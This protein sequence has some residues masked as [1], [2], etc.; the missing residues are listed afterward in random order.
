MKS[1]SIR[2]WWLVLVP[3][4]IVAPA[5]S[6]VATAGPSVAD[7]PTLSG[8]GRNDRLQIGIAGVYDS[9]S[10]GDV[11]D[12]PTALYDGADSAL[13]GVGVRR[14][15][16][17]GDFGC[18]LTTEAAVVCWGNN[19]QSQYGNGTGSG[20]AYPA[21]P[22]KADGA[23]AG[24]T[25]VDVKVGLNT[26]C[27]LTSDGKVFCWGTQN[28]GNGAQGRAG[29]GETDNSVTL[30]EPKQIDMSGVL[31]GE[32]ISQLGYG[33]VGGCVVTTTGKVACW[34]WSVDGA[35]GSDFSDPYAFSPVLVDDSAWPG[36]TVTSIA[37]ASVGGCALT[38]ADNA[39]CWGRLTSPSSSTPVAVDMSPLDGAGV[40]RSITVG[41][42]S[43][44][45]ATSIGAVFCWGS[46][47]KGQLGN[48]ATT[49]SAIPVRVDD[50]AFGSEKV[51][52]ISGMPLAMCARTDAFNAYCW[53]LNNDLF[54]AGR[55]GNGSSDAQS[56]VPVAVATDTALAGRYV[57]RLAH[58]SSAN[59][60]LA[61]S[62]ATVPDAPVNVEVELATTSIVYGDATPSVVV[63]A[64]DPV[65]GEPV[66]GSITTGDCTVYAAGT[67]TVVTDEP[68]VPGDYEVACDVTANAG[69]EIAGNS[70]VPL[71]VA[72]A[73]LDCVVTD[74]SGV[75][76]G[77]VH[78][79]SATCTGIGADS[80]AVDAEPGHSDVGQYTDT[81]SVAETDR[82]NAAS[83]TATV[84][85][86]SSVSPTTGGSQSPG[87]TSSVLPTTGASQWP[88]VLA[89]ASLMLG[90]VLMLLGRRQPS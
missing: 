72:K 76:D 79:A 8:W 70:R 46:G 90:V 9:Q 80:F 17:G 14:A 66:E 64:L 13:Y 56:D 23:L 1:R 27:A 81:W 29:T 52:E 88:A 32:T 15:S 12:K 28:A 48:G 3:M 42:A 77:Q 54:G 51:V 44:C 86:T 82:Y 40:A 74:Y 43:A 60:M 26:G 83:G 21:V 33:S 71:T 16:A 36:E 50:T 7:G 22:V 38:D 31:A 63:T 55:L 87:A 11:Y 20:P 78:N 73:D 30:S 47:A 69:Y 2:R 24:K 4:M 19:S 37:V 62:Q 58:A 41:S 49:N 39:Y 53:G 10:F 59:F 84:T 25:V 85:I 65:S 45:V 89:F 34:G 6:S 18:A 67:S 61:I 57:T 35:L 5:M 75:D 68:L